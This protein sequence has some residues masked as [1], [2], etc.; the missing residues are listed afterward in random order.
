MFYNLEK[1]DERKNTIRKG[2][3]KDIMDYEKL[4]TN[5]RELFYK[6]QIN[7]IY[8]THKTYNASK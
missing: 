3:T 7:H 2:S 4:Y 1:N 5:H 8:K 6:Y